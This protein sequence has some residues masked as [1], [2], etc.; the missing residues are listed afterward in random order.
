MEPGTTENEQRRIT[1]ENIANERLRLR[2]A[3]NELEAASAAYRDAV[4]HLRRI[5]PSERAT[6]RSLGISQTALRDLLRSG[7]RKSR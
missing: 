6:A 7:R 4:A 2:Q 5:S 3:Q 1:I